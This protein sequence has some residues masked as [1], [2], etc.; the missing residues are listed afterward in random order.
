MKTQPGRMQGF[1]IVKDKYGRIK[2]DNWANLT[3]EQR[4]IIEY[5]ELKNGGNTHRSSTKRDS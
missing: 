5:E 3:P 2:R 1:A 4:K